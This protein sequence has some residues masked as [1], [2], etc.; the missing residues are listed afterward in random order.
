MQVNL[1]KEAFYE[2][3]DKKATSIPFETF[4]NMCGVTMNGNG[5]DRYNNI[6]NVRLFTNVEE[7]KG[8]S[9]TE[10]ES[11]DTSQ[12]V[13]VL[14]KGNFCIRLKDKPQITTKNKKHDGTT[15]TEKNTE[16]KPT[17]L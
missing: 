7:F 3:D 16:D 4:I 8:I 14:P 6:P 2:L 5:S 9:K 11:L 15:S 17:D 1:I 10:M 13:L 12:N